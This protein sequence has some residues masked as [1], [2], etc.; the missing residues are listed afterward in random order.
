[1]QVTN[2][3]KC[4]VSVKYCCLHIIKIRNIHKSRIK[5]NFANGGKSDE[6][7]KTATTTTTATT[8]VKI[9]SSNAI[10]IY[11]DL[12]ETQKNGYVINQI[13]NCFKKG[14]VINKRKRGDLDIDTKRV[15]SDIENVIINNDNNETFDHAKCSLITIYGK[16]GYIDKALNIFN[17]NISENKKDIICIGSIMNACNNNKKYN[18]CISIYYEYNKYKKH[19]DVTNLLFI[20]ACINTNNYEKANKL[21]DS[22]INKQQDL[23]NFSIEFINTLIDFYGKIGDIDNALN[24]FNKIISQNRE[25]IICIN[26]MMNI[27]NNN[28]EYNKC[29]SI[30]Q[31][32]VNIH[33]DISHLL[34]I[35]ACINSNNYGKAQK[36]INSLLLLENK[37]NIQ[38]HSIEFITTLIDFYGKIGDIN[39][40]LQIF[41]NIPKNKMNV[42][43]ISAM[44]NTYNKNNK[45]QETILLYEQYNNK[46]NNNDDVSNLLFINACINT[47][48]YHKA[49]KLI[50]INI[51][52]KTDVNNH[53][54]EFIN[55][56]IDFYGRIGDINNALSVFDN[57]LENK[58][59]IITINVM[60]NAY[61]NNQEYN[62]TISLYE[63]YNNKY[64]HND[65]SKLLFIKACI[66]N[67]DYHK[68]NKL[69]KSINFKDINNHSIELINTLIDYFGKIG[70]IDNALN[71]F[72]NIT[73][74]KQD[75]V[76]IGAMMNAYNNNEQYDKTI[77]FYEEYNGQHNDVTNL[78]FINA[79]INTGDYE[80][81]KMFINSKI[82]NKDI[83]NH[84]IE[85]TNG[86]ID[87]YGK[88]GD[89][90]NALNVFNKIPENKKDFISINCMM[91]AFN[92]N[93]QCDK[94]ILLYQK[95]NN[96]GKNNN[97]VSNVLFTKACSNCGDYDKGKQLFNNINIKNINNHSIEFI[98]SL[99]DFYGKSNDINKAFE[100]F[101]NICENN[102]NS[103]SIA[104][105]MNAFNFNKKY[106]ETINL[107][108][109][110]IND[111]N[112]NINDY[113]YC[114]ALIACGNIVSLNNGLIIINH[115][116]KIN[117]NCNILQSLYIQSAIITFYGKCN[118]FEQAL[119][120]F[121][122]EINKYNK[123]KDKD[124]HGL[125]YLYSSM[126][127]CYVKKGDIKQLLLL[128]NDLKNNKN[129]KKI[130]KCIF[131]IVLN[132][133]CY[134]GLIDKAL[135]IFDE[136]KYKYKY[137][138][139]QS[140][141]PLIDC[142]GKKGGDYYLN[143]AENL[144]KI[145]IENNKN[146]YYKFKLD[147]LFSILSSCY[148]HN[149]LYRA[150]KIFNEM[151]VILNESNVNNNNDILCKMYV[152]L[153][154]IYAKNKKF[155]KVNEIN[156]KMKEKGIKK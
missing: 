105:M 43:S 44:M 115:L 4:K 74:N 112:I 126:M 107:F 28:K 87:F 117:K 133:Y 89:I 14:I 141:N 70:D 68:G 30:Y 108:N 40:A 96:N 13:L 55:T 11:N 145:Y 71:I 97:D 84:S 41:N 58:K 62:K 144:Y 109:K 120:I 150:Q 103:S 95:Y 79:C 27:Y 63:K 2:Y 118:K 25:N 131:N 45:Y 26:T 104:A 22:L 56:L 106:N 125:L 7:T 73:K 85:F 137:I 83:N 20:K 72:N 139:I 111:K 98:T 129:I 53:S 110:I 51:K 57:I 18:K 153:S 60:M 147:A 100:I 61:N 78:L 148:I 76:S 154:N 143:K 19:N 17:N 114:E 156:K 127:D 54:I 116:N 23:N 39:K 91:N 82:K 52:N 102:M 35:K 8:L 93:E 128:F 24:I 119:N 90:D 33:N 92:N 146:I 151:S 77:K 75:I 134:L 130:P 59:D 155:D 140:I 50:N 10:K 135:L 142:L 149:D 49:K 121:N 88:T 34:F 42:I 48:N 9:N 16:I 46:Y 99:I 69:I 138:D 6:Y 66:N 124:N 32:Y 21:I 3:S 37:K 80:K 113:I 5:N 38:N 47:N 81:G 65:V 101:N 36:L 152:L 136:I 15:I 122:Q 132:G 123:N 86:L 1:M 67:N 12:D 31:Q 29:I 64:T 94:S